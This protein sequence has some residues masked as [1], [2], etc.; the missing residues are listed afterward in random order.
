M[1]FVQAVEQPLK[2]LLRAPGWRPPMLY[3]PKV[4]HSNQVKRGLGFD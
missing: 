2:G 1:A 4:W 3:L